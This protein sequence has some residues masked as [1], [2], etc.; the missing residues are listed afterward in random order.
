MGAPSPRCSVR[1]PTRQMRTR[2]LTLGEVGFGRGLVAAEAGAGAER[3]VRVPGAHLPDA[4]DD[5]VTGLDEGLQ[6]TALRVIDVEA[7]G[8]TAVG[9]EHVRRSGADGLR[10]LG[11]VERIR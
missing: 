5:A 4:H 10:L 3:E 6:A 11:L 1:T 7:P 2:L 9:H 8:R